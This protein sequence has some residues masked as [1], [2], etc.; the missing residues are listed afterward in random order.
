[1]A[2]RPES[3]SDN[4]SKRPGTGSDRY[5]KAVPL[6]VCLRCLN[7]NI[8]FR[9]AV[10]VNNI[11]NFDDVVIKRVLRDG[12]YT[13]FF[14]KLKHKEREDGRFTIKDFTKI[15]GPVSLLCFFESY[16]LIRKNHG[17]ILH[18]CGTFENFEFILYTNAEVECGRQVNFNETNRLS[19]L[20]SG[21]GRGS[22]ITFKR[23][24]YIRKYLKELKRCK[25][26]LLDQRQPSLFKE[27]FSCEE[28]KN[29]L[30]NRTLIKK[31]LN[32]DFSLTKD[33]L[34]KLK[35]L[36]RQSPVSGVEQ[37]ISKE[38]E[39]YA[40]TLACESSDR[41]SI[42]QQ[43]KDCFFRWCNKTTTAEYLTESSCVW[44]NAVPEH[45][46]QQ[47]LLPPS[48]RQPCF[49]YNQT[50]HL[51]A[52]CPNR[53]TG[54]WLTKSSRVR[55]NT[56]PEHVA[57]Q[58]RFPPS[59]RQHC[60]ICNQT[61]HLQTQ[62]PYRKCYYCNQ[63]GHLQAQCPYRKCYYCNQTGHLQTQ[64]PYRKCYYCNQTGH[65]QAQCPKLM[66]KSDTEE[67]DIW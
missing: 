59:N 43:I 5:E 30:G 62:Y 49:I 12:V 56:I 4:Y 29:N 50:D 47:Q 3:G 1:V 64:C 58:Q 26:L 46:A 28:I 48:N 16:C 44:Q 40:N 60:C 13:T 17:D 38:L 41:N 8:T 19:I 32:C 45:V 18:S 23:D 66:N 7:N 39:V 51:Q 27:S 55:L 25:N 57:Q 54:E 14:V 36:K 2:V 6:L 15:S 9:L 24:G 10:N 34:K 53:K 65:L 31:L 63:T 11:G 20:S 42:S 35:I 61:G 67:E 52:Q 33:F 37:S 22:Y 21:P